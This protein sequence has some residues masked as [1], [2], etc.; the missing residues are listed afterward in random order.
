MYLLW[1]QIKPSAALVLYKELNIVISHLFF[2]RSVTIDPPRIVNFAD[3]A[4]SHI[5]FDPNR[6]VLHGQ[7]VLC[8]PTKRLAQKKLVESKF[9]VDVN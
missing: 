8:G 2:V 3:F 1:A 7:F 4:A 9:C 6:H 5:T